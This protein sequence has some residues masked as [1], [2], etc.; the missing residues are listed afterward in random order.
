[1]SKKIRL[2]MTI[3]WEYDPNDGYGSYEWAL[4]FLENFRNGCIE[5]PNTTIE[6]S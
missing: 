4:K 3:T 5:Y 1:M 2:S 6:V